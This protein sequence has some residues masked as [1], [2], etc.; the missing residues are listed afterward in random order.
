LLD[1]DRDPKKATL[2]EQFAGK[3][4]VFIP[5][6]PA[7]FDSNVSKFP[8][9]FQSWLDENCPTSSWTYSREVIPETKI[10]WLFF[11]FDTVEQATL[12]KLRWWG[13]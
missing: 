2:R 11:A 5:Y 8:P 3:P 1:S 12:F 10:N 6:S 13:E 4:Y 9:E 7:I